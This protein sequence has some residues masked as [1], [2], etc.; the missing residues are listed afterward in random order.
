MAVEKLDELENNVRSSLLGEF[1]IWL[2]CRTR[3]LGLPGAP[4]SLNLQGSD[5]PR[6]RTQPVFSPEHLSFRAPIAL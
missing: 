1:R 3:F 4:L 2:S 5:N 6:Q